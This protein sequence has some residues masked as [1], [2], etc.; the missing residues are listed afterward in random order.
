MRPCS[1]A[2]VPLFPVEQPCT[3]ALVPW[4][5]W[6]SALLRGT[7]LRCPSWST[8]HRTL[9]RFSESKACWS[10]TNSRISQRSRSTCGSPRLP[11]TSWWRTSCREPVPRPQSV[12]RELA[13]PPYSPRWSCHSLE[14]ISILLV[15]P[16][17]SF[18]YTSQS[19]K[20][21]GGTGGRSP[22]IVT[23]GGPVGT[24]VP[25]G[26]YRTSSLLS[27]APLRSRG[28]P[29]DTSDQSEF[30][31]FSSIFCISSCILRRSCSFSSCSVLTTSFSTSLCKSSPPWSAWKTAPCDL[32]GSPPL[33][34]LPSAPSSG[35]L[36][37]VLR[38]PP[39][40]APWFIQLSGVVKAISAIGVPSLDRDR[41]L[42]LSS[43]P[44]STAAKSC[45]SSCSSWRLTSSSSPGTG[46]LSGGKSIGLLTASRNSVVAF[47]DQKGLPPP[48][49]TD[50]P[51]RIAMGTE[52]GDQHVVLGLITCSNDETGNALFWTSKKSLR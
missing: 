14:S 18:S 3:G 2:L 42:P 24:W 46:Y 21:Q 47:S 9:D 10:C 31:D 5:P 27:A 11:S 43:L 12:C 32:S 22:S 49:G 45:S 34:W 40:T 4:R 7:S 39:V 6:W 44:F 26:V 33:A 29:A 19:G 16:P 52:K 37:A 15:W 8:L 20:G 36:P 38:G 30:P 23:G 17:S 50:E 1:G 41:L 48:T 25:L 28:D 35:I 51:L 13:P